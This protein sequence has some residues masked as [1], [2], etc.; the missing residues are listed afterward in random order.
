MNASIQEVRDAATRLPAE[1]PYYEQIQNVLLRAVSQATD[2][3]LYWEEMGKPHLRTFLKTTP[4]G[5]AILD[6]AR[7]INNQGDS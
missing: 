5:L 3:E 4:L 2:D 1:T 6:L 7:T